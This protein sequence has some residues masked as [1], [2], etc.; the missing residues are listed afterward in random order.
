MARTK[1]RIPAAYHDVLA[2]HRARL[3]RVTKGSGLKQMEA[4]YKSTQAQLESKLRKLVGAGRGDTMTAAQ[5][6][7]LLAQARQGQ[8][9]L[10]H[11]MV[12]QLG[13]LSNEAQVVALRGLEKDLAKLD[14]AFEVSQVT[15]PIAEAG[16]FAGVIEGRAQS[17][18][19]Q[20]MSSMSNW[21]VSAV[22]N[23]KTSLATSLATGETV[24]EAVSRIAETTDA[25]WWRVERVVVTETSWAAAAATSDG[26]EDAKQDAVPD[27]LSRWVELVSDETG[28]PMDDRVG[29][30]S[31]AIHA[32]VTD[33]GGMF[34]MPA[35]SD[36]P[37]AKG[38]TA[39]SE[40]LVGKSWPHPPD[41][42]ND[43]SLIQ[44]WRAS[45]G[46]PGWRYN[47]GERDWIV[48]MK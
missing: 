35:E 16:R 33:P 31:L 18:L 7:V 25:Q 6:R 2:E 41:R 42:P 44:G 13:E 12:G 22:G 36:V 20:H 23:I 19:E 1:G 17:L 38:R 34:T 47:G 10:A 37:D 5:A 30:D 11:A 8:A 15:L 26:L 46:I 45:W 29:V 43:R 27:L 14:A 39:V 28:E 40:A 48:P 32:Q 21:G 9:Q 4:F 3:H 24:H